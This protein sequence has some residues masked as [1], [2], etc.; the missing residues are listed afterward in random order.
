MTSLI[1]THFDCLY[2]SCRIGQAYRLLDQLAASRHLLRSDICDTLLASIRREIALELA[3]DT[4][5]AEDGGSIALA[6]DE[7][8]LGVT[9]QLRSGGFHVKHLRTGK[10]GRSGEAEVGPSTIGL[11][12][13]NDMSTAMDYN[14][15]ASLKRSAHGN[16]P[17]H[18]SYPS[19]CQG[20]GAS[21][22]D[23]NLHPWAF[24]VLGLGTIFLLLTLSFVLSSEKVRSLCS[25]VSW[26]RRLSPRGQ[27]RCR[28]SFGL[29]QKRMIYA[30]PLLIV[31]V[32]EIS[33][34][35]VGGDKDQARREASFV[36]RLSRV[37]PGSPS[38]KILSESILDDQTATAEVRSSATARPSTDDNVAV[39][40]AD[41][42]SYTYP[43]FLFPFSHV[44]NISSSHS[45]SPPARILA[46]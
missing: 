21:D 29:V 19:F 20:K 15:E 5:I 8:G 33:A 12:T 28:R 30:L 31:L 34:G 14:V 42:E 36:S 18:V 46:G 38:K 40:I 22:G 41:V 26:H 32:A 10:I 4:G 2:C 3:H 25:T 11:S 43:S 44:E 39:S 17:E 23:V 24:F 45:L 35:S 6:N 7:S 1:D 37:L 13:H 27:K 9:I 16:R